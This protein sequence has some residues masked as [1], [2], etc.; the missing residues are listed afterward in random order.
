[1][2]RLRSSWASGGDILCHTD[3]VR[4]W[5]NSILSAALGNKREFFLYSVVMFQACLW[6]H[7]GAPEQP[8]LKATVG[9]S[10]APCPSST[11]PCPTSPLWTQW[12]IFVS[13]PFQGPRYI[14]PYLVGYQSICL[15]FSVWQNG[16]ACYSLTLILYHTHAHS[17]PLK[18]LMTLL[19]IVL[20]KKTNLWLP[21]SI[22]S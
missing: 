7:H 8:V 6:Q 19:C 16:L 3:R 5:I 18:P 9:S 13:A 14:S 2:Q 4:H 1:M 12:H 17:R 22:E 15:T 20:C 10:T 11:A 21:S